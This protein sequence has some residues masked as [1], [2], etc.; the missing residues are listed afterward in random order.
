MTDETKSWGGPREGSGRKRKKVAEKQSRKAM[1]TFTPAEYRE[2][3]VAAG[4]EPVGTFIRK[5][6]LR[7]LA[8]RR[9]R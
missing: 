5:L 6:V 1:S 3:K 9:K 2:L 7:Y 8:R 4:D